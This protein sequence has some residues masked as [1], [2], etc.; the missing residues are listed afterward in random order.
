MQRLGPFFHPIWY[1]TRKN[2]YPMKTSKFLTC[3]IL[4][5]SMATSCT[6]DDMPDMTNHD[7]RWEKVEPIQLPQRNEND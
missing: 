3:A 6:K 1:E 7:H 2:K 5:L 4:A